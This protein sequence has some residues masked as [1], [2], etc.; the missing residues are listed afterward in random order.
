VTI[1]RFGRARVNACA[2][3]QRHEIRSQRSSPP[4][5]VR[6]RTRTPPLLPA[7]PSERAPAS[8]SRDPVR[9]RHSRRTAGPPPHSSLLTSRHSSAA[10]GSAQQLAY[11][12]ATDRRR[13]G[14]PAAPALPRERHRSM[15]RPCSRGAGSIPRASPRAVRYRRRAR[16]GDVTCRV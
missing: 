2:P 16:G 5:P 14:A 13:T 15:K 6:W 4:A 11:A 12:R 7:I 9:E 10:R 8:E 3:L 1:V